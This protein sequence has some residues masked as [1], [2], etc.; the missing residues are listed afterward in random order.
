MSADFRTILETVS[1]L[2]RGDEQTRAM[3][4]MRI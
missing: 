2:W 4:T 1:Y 3:V